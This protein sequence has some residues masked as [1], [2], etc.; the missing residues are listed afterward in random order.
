M[1]F[2][3]D[4]TA[5]DMLILVVVNLCYSVLKFLFLLL[6]QTSFLLFVSQVRTSVERGTPSE[7]YYVAN[8]VSKRNILTSIIQQS[9]APLNIVAQEVQKRSAQKWFATSRPYPA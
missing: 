1:N 2:C 7:I 6:F 4:L 5:R 8:K 9:P 3:D